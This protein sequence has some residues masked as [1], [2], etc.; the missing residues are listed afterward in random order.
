MG[1]PILGD[2]IY[3]KKDPIFPEATL[4]LHARRL[5]ISLPSRSEPSI[6]KACLP[7]RFTEIITFLNQHG[8]IRR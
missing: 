5:K 1:C 6:F 4:M 7:E 8:A 2:P 3:A